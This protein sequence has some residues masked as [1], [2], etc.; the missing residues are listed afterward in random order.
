MSN[1]LKPCPKCGA[2]I[3]PEAP[4]GLC[5]KCLLAFVSMPTEAAPPVRERPAPPSL[6][7]IAAAFPQLEILDLVGQGG[8]GV[9]F[10]ARQPRLDRFVALKILPQSL[11]TDSAFAERFTREGRLL[12]RLAHPNIVAVHDF[13]QAGGYFFL[14]MEF[15]DGVNLRQAMQAGRFT[16]EQALAVVP[17]VCEALQYAHH[18]GVLHRDIKPENIL[19]DARGR[20]KIADFGIAKLVGDPRAEGALTGSGAR[21]GTPHYMAPEQIESPGRVDHRADIYSLGVVFYEM[22]TGELPLGRFA[23]PSEKSTADPRLDEVVFRSLEKEPARRQQSIDEVRK[24]VE[25]IATTAP[26]G[27]GRDSSRAKEAQPR[28]LR[29]CSSIVTNADQ[30]H[31]F[32][33]KFFLYRQKGVLALDER[34]LTFTHPGASAKVFELIGELTL[35]IPLESIRDL[36]LGTY[37]RFVNPAGIAF[38][39]V[40]FEH[41]GQTKRLFFT[42]MEGMIG[43]PWTVNQLVDEWFGAIRDTIIA[44]TGRAPTQSPAAQLGVSSR[45]SPWL[46]LMAVPLLAPTIVLIFR[47]STRGMAILLSL[48]AV[49]AVIGGFVGLGAFVGRIGRGRSK[50]NPP[51]NPWPARVFWLVAGLVGVPVALVIIGLFVP[52]F[53]RS[54]APPAP[55]AAAATVDLPTPV[56]NPAIDVLRVQLRQ[57]EEALTRSQAM[58]NNGT[59]TSG[60]LQSARDAVDILKAEISGDPIETARVRLAAAQRQLTAAE[61]RFKVGA[62]PMAE[63]QSAKDAVEVLDAKLQAALGSAKR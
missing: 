51:G 27:S 2:A 53:L 4:Q 16:P 7:Q 22:L 48:A 60:E 42:P 50:S 40:T 52:Y 62:M 21:L 57:A 28:L 31:T 1:D 8:M 15:V 33:G 59:I 23:P 54:H 3:P 11:A 10:K 46:L 14:L 55:V 32:E 29:S 49:A 44:A 43:A 24:E 18:E 26:G 63:Y 58:F 5:P 6:E 41:S 20:V 61:A 45:F 38:I 25:T 37:P 9:V 12:A 35:R 36:S 39:S 34:Q 19:L 17:R 47:L 13:G 30:L 56:P